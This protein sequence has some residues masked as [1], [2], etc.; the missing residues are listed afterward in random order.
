MLGM[1][2]SGTSSLAGCLQEYGLHLGEVVEQA[3]HNLRG[4]R[5]SLLIREVNDRVLE[6]NSSAWDRPPAGAIVWDD[7]H[8]A[9]RDRAVEAHATS[10][11]PWGFKDP[12][13]LFTLE[14]WQEGLPSLELVGTFRH[15]RAVA[16][17][18]TTRNGWDTSRGMELW[19]AYNRR[20]LALHME[21]PFPL[22]S[23][24]LP[25]ADYAT[26]ITTTAQQLGLT[27]RSVPPG[28]FTDDLRHQRGE[29]DEGA[30]PADVHE[31]HDALCRRSI[32][33]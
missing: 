6:H 10:D 4:N 26:V 22:V 25:A 16:G 30:L 12:R 8:R 21:Q 5:E 2:R 24:D 28:F 18:L 11:R 32:Q 20:L 1:H 23:F 15:P 3:P 9:L 33:P 7:A 19:L 13:T 29:R 17:S 14:F 31:V 27:D